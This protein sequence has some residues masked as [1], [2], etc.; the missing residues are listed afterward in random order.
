MKTFWLRHLR[1]VLFVNIDRNNWISLSYTSDRHG[2]IAA[3]GVLGLETGVEYARK[4]PKTG[5]S[6]RVFDWACIRNFRQR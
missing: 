2:V 6:K 5:Y 4:T 1:L 3:V